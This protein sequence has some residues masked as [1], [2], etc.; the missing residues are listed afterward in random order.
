MSREQAQQILK[1][2]QRVAVATHV[3]P[4]ADAI[5][6]AT[7]LVQILRRLGKTAEAFCDDDLPA[8]L[9]AIPHVEE[10]ARIARG[11]FDLLVSVD[12]SDP[13]RLGKAFA[14]LQGLPLLNIDHHVTNTRFGT[15]NWVDPSAVATAEMVLWLA[16]DLGVALDAELASILLAGIVGDTMGLRTANVNARILREVTRLMEAGAS[17]PALVDALFNRRPLAAVRLFGQALVGVQVESGVIWT[18]ITRE[19]RA[20]SGLTHAND[21]SLSSFLIGVEEARIAA[22]FTER[23]DGK[24][25]VSMRARPGYDVARVALA[26]GGGGHPP[27]AGCL[28]PGPMEEVIPLILAALKTAARDSQGETSEGR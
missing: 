25:E 23:D 13:G 8:R 6:S 28:L 22:V 19:M 5:S 14:E 11:S 16:E 15:I 7:G 2:A 4:D 27:A 21:L 3:S 26:F 20:A 18:V 24:V 10:I 9:K 12:A 17:L 1:E